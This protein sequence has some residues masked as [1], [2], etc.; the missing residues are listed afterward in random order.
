MLVS[1]LMKNDVLSVAPDT[2]LAD[3]ARIMLAQRV[4]GLPVLNDSGHLVGVVTEGDLL[5]RA[6][7]GTEGE[8]PSW[9]KTFL[10]P[11]RLAE[12]Y[13]H[14]HGRHV[15]EVMTEQPIFIAPGT[16]LAEVAALM[17][18]KHIKRLPVLEN[19]TLVGVI[20]RSNLLAALS[21]KLIETAAKSSDDS[22][23][24]YILAELKRE[25]WAPKSGIRVHVQEKVVTL[26]GVIFNEAV[27][28]A[29]RVAAAQGYGQYSKASTQLHVTGTADRLGYAF[30]YGVGSLDGPLKNDYQYQPGA[31]FDQSAVIPG[32]NPAIRDL[33][34]YKDD[35]LAVSR[36]GLAKVSYALSSTSKITFT[37]LVSSYWND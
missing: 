19:G 24:D 33:G 30:A 37:S 36:S 27:R 35:S 1:D 32:A 4:S 7:L 20:S 8:Q 17:H 18:N 26:E 15:S 22:I 2:T 25:R 34:V 16:S 23:G 31:A 10:V 9:L 14:T 12:D 29:L 28:P 11:S 13:V 21:R 3:A 6:E 5:R